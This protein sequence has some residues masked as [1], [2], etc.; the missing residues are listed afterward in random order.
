V[1]AVSRSS[2]YRWIK[3]APARA[4]RASADAALAEEVKRIHGEFDCTHGSPRI[5]AEL[6]ANGRRVNHKEWRG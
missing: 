6:H 4:E 3:A 2:F 5:T 1:L